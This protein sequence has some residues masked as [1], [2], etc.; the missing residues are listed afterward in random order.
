V[1]YHSTAERSIAGA[2]AGQNSRRCRNSASAAASPNRCAEEVV[3]AKND[4]VM[5]LAGLQE[6][7]AAAFGTAARFVAKPFDKLIADRSTK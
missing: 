1:A 7:R 4:G 3:L 5:E 6:A 2:L